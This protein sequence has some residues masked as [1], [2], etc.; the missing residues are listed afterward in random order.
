MPYIPKERRSRVLKEFVLYR[1]TTAGDM[2]FFI[3]AYVHA[4]L[5]DQGLCYATINEMIGVLECAKLELYR[6]IAAPYE[7]KKRKENGPISELD[8][9][10][11][12]DQTNSTVTK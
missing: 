1:E 10:A 11:P 3:T 5:K 9:G 7:D 8:E 4:I 6:M 12:N 2:N